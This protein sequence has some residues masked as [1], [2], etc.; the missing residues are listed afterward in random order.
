MVAEYILL[1]YTFQYSW[2]FHISFMITTFLILKILYKN[3]SQIIDIF[4]LL[5]SY[6][7]L[8]ITSILCC[9]IFNFNMIFVSIL[10]RIII[11]GTIIFLNKRLNKIQNFYKCLWNRNDLIKKKIKSTTFRAFN[12]VI[13]NIIFYLI[14]ICMLYAIYYKN[15]IE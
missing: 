3:K 1:I 15:Y 6:I 9:F 2:L 4:I 8:G 12:I 11:F 13:F 14:N 10:N 5:I 7:F